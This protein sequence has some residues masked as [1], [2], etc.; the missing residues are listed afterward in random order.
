MEAPGEIAADTAGEHEIDCLSGAVDGGLDRLG[1]FAH[2]RSGLNEFL[3]ISL[4]S[5]AAGIRPPA[6]PFSEKEKRLTR[7]NNLPCTPTAYAKWLAR[8][9]SSQVKQE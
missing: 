8:H 9:V 2:L 1:E 3:F 4:F 7:L 6:S 5:F